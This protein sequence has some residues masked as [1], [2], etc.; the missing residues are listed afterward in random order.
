MYR[1]VGS[2][3]DLIKEAARK[4]EPEGLA[5]V[6]EEQVRGRGRLGRVWTAPPG[7]SVLCSILLRPR[8]PAEQA[9]YLTIAAALAIYRSA[10]S[11]QWAVG[12]DRRPATDDQPPTTGDGTTGQV[13]PQSAIRNPQLEGPHSAFRIPH[14]AIKWPNDVL[15]NGKKVAGILSESEFVGGEWVFAVIGFGINANLGA[16]DLMELRAVAPR[17]LRFRQNGASR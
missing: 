14:S 6:A 10:G 4:G 1:Q 17:P 2:T 5:V 12:R 13:N 11:A 16:D 7:S 8:F 15:I 9:F 3:N